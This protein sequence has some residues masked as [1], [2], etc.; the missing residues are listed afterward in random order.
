MM[1]KQPVSWLILVSCLWI[2]I[3]CIAPP[4]WALNQA[5]DHSGFAYLLHKYVESST[6]DYA[7]FQREE[8]QLDKYLETMAGV[9][10]DDLPRNDQ[11][12][13]YINLYN[14]WTIKL[15]LSE[16]PGIDS[17]KDIGGF[18]GSPWKQKIVR[19]NGKTITLDA[20]EHEILRPRFADPR[21]HFAI[22]CASI[23]CPPLTSRPYQGNL[24]DSQLDDVTKS[25]LNDPSKNRLTGNTL[26]VTKIFKWFKKDFNGDIIV[27]FMTYGSEDLKSNLSRQKKQLRIEYLDYDWS[28]NGK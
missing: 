23:G 17:I 12:A 11:F 15:I 16:Y 26:Y 18:F 5:V 27:F 20:V 1:T 10:A 7:G 19:V 8:A 22:N 28:L 4:S 24:I 6:V 9:A 2:G 21:V 13:F 14:A 3:A 25:F